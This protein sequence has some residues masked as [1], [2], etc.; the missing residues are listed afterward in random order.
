MG[1]FVLFITAMNILILMLF[2]IKL[3]PSIVFCRLFYSFCL[4]FL[5]IRLLDL[6]CIWYS[7]SFLN[8]LL[9]TWCVCVMQGSTYY[10]DPCI[11]CMP[12]FCTKISCVECI[13]I[14]IIIIIIITTIIWPL[15]IML[16][17]I[18]RQAW[19]CLYQFYTPMVHV[20]VLTSLETQIKKMFF[21]TENH[22]I[23]VAGTIHT[24]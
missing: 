23:S 16:I 6:V 4:L 11:K 13:I 10:A 7:K 3:Y 15:V 22:N 1:V 8:F 5:S 9:E 2:G 18:Y 19:M 21:H 20:V 24:F 14:I 17:R 12:R